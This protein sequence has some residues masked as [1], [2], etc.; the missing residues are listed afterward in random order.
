MARGEF[1]DA[2][3]ACGLITPRPRRWAE[4]YGLD[5][6]PSNPY[7]AHRHDYEVSDWDEA[8]AIL[9]DNQCL[10]DMNCDFDDEESEEVAQIQYD[11]AYAHFQN[12]DYVECNIYNSLSSVLVYLSED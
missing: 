3:K 2:K 5:L 6:N 9:V 7:R 12:H 11:E 10:P 8:Y 1:K 4:R